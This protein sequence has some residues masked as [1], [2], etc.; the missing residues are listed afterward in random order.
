MTGRTQ[1][2]KSPLREATGWLKS[3]L[4]AF[5]LV[6]LVS[7]LPGMPMPVIG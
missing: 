5:A 1:G 2:K 3:F 6:L 4:G 7:T